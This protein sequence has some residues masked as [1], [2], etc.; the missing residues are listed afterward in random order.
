[1]CIVT[2]PAMPK[3]EEFAMI[4]RIFSKIK[5]LLL[6]STLI[7]FFCTGY[8]Y[9]AGFALIEQSV[10]G[11]GNAF[12]GGAAIAEDATTIFFNPAGMV[13]LQEQQL[14]LGSHVIIPSVKFHNEEST[15]LL[16]GVTG[17]PLSGGNGGNGG[18]TK[19]IPNAYYAKKIKNNISAGIG[20]NAPFGL[21]TEYDKDWVGRYHAI[22][23]DVL[24]LNINP[25]V[26]YRLN[27]HLS[28]G[29]GFNAQ[30][31]K[32]KLSSAIDFGTL[33]AIGRLGVSPNTFG[34]IPQQSDG[35]MALE[36]ESWGIGYNLGVLYEFN[37]NT[38]IG[39]AYRSKI[40]HTLDGD[41]DFSNVPSALN[42]IPA[43][44]DTDAESEI[45]LPDSLS[46]SFLHRINQKLT[47]IADFTWTNWRVF[48]ELKIEFDNPNQP[49]SI[50]TEDWQDSYRYSIGLTYNPT[51]ELSLRIGTAYD[52]SAVPNKER[53]T[54]RIPDGDRIWAACGLG[55]KISKIF[56]VDL[57]YA[58]LF[59][60]DPQIDK[61][62]TDEDAIRGGLK[63]KFDAYIDIIS[64]QINLVF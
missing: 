49:D 51:N 42:S 18:V 29:L 38:R 37:E 63:G 24:T 33:D 55:Y 35:Y 30:Y 50:T 6:L 59:I 20:I 17:M 7:F 4:I 21:A 22:E 23:S 52:T 2:N 53:R 57:A 40:K 27:D 11:M 14:I 45:T 19:F 5:T 60:N 56:F 47:V 62:T 46:I 25:S 10:S 15:H 28:I 16:Q 31:L 1:M 26:A 64:A 13:R 43:F 9:G 36:G 54:P 58:H 12:A 44:K 8:S 48:D 39:I 32:A 41:A 34:L 61:E 3:K